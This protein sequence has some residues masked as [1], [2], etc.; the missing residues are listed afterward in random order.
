MLEVGLIV[1]QGMGATF[2]LCQTTGTCCFAADTEFNLHTVQSV[3]TLAD[4]S[5]WFTVEMAENFHLSKILK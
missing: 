1:V 5:I 2:F 4:D 3:V